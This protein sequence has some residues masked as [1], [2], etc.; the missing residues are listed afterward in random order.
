M[1]NWYVSS[2][3]Y[4]NVTQ[5]AA[6][7]AYSIGA[8]RRQLA[9]PAVNSERCFRVSATSGISGGSEPSWVLTHNATTTDSGITWI[10]CTAQEAYQHIGSSITWTAPAARIG[11]INLNGENIL[12]AGDNVY[13]SSDHAE[14]QSSANTLYVPGTVTAPNEFISVNRTGSVPPVAGDILAGASINTTGANTINILQNSC[15][16]YWYGFTFSAGNSSNLANVS[17][18]DAAQVLFDTCKF[19]LNNTN[20][21]SMIELGDNTWWKNCTVTFGNSTQAISTGNLV[22]E[23]TNVAALAGTVPLN[24]FNFTVSAAGSLYLKGLDLSSITT[25]IGTGTTGGPADFNLQNCKLNSSVTLVSSS[26]VVTATGN[27]QIVLESINGGGGN[28]YSHI[29]RTA[30]GTVMSN[31]TYYRSSG[32]TDGVQEASRQ[33]TSDST[34]TRIMPAWHDVFMW[35]TAVSGVTHTAS[36]EVLGTTMLTNAQLWGEVEYLGSS[37]SSLG[38]FANNAAATWLTSPSN[39]PTSS[40]GWSGSLVG[41]VMQKLQVSFVPKTVGLIKFRIYLALPSVVIYVDPFITL[42]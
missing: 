42:T 14:T 25:A 16:G 15:A 31:V 21:G 32:A 33:M 34:A 23:N 4:G 10:E 5:W 41:A 24:L 36:V 28:N 39:Q 22:W 37:G 11:D 40:A 8:I 20:V 1:S 9:A 7:T 17:I 6:S 38:Y 27:A 18:N 35:N 26:A 29:W 30:T 3:A 19:V 13:C 2:V 12:V